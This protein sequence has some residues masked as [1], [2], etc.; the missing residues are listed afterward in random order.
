MLSNFKLM[1]VKGGL[2]IYITLCSMYMVQGVGIKEFYNLHHGI[3][4]LGGTF[5]MC[6]NGLAHSQ[7]VVLFPIITLLYI[8]AIL[9]CYKLM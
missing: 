2:Y 3:I 4:I 1:V 8:M 6:R 9:C 5:Y 7:M